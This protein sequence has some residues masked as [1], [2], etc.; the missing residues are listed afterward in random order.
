MAKHTFQDGIN[1]VF[2]DELLPNTFVRYLYNG[3]ILSQGE[4]NVGIIT[5][6]KG[7]TQIPFNLPTG[8]NKCIGTAVDEENGKLYWFNYNNTNQHGIYQF[9]RLNKVITPVLLSLEDTGGVDILRFN[10]DY[11]ILHAEVIKG[12]LYWVDGLN[13]ARNFS[14][15]KMLDQG[16]N[17]YGLILEQYINAYKQTSPFPPVAIYASDPS[18]KF[19]KL[20]GSLRKFSIRYVYDGGE[21]SNWSDFSNVPLPSYESFTGVNQIP[22]DNNLINV[23][24]ATGDRTVDKI[25]VAVLTTNYETVGADLPWAIVANIDKDKLVVSDNSQYTFKYYND[26]APITTDN[27]KIIRPYSFMPKRPLCMAFLKNA[28]SYANGYMGFESIDIDVDASV[29]YSDLFIEDGQENEF[30]KPVFLHSLPANGADYV[31]DHERLWDYNNVEGFLLARDAPGRFNIHQITVGNDVKAGNKFRLQLTNGSDNFVIEVTAIN[32]DTSGTIINKIRQQL[33]A[34]P[35]RIFRRTE[36]L[37]DTNIFDQIDDGSGNI[38]IKFII[39]ASKN[40]PYLQGSASVQP[41]QFNTLK[42]TGQSVRNIKMGSQTKYGLMYEDFDGRKSLVYTDNN[43]IV[44]IQTFNEAGEIK[45]ST[46]T[47]NINHLPP[48]WARYYQVVRSSDLV[49][50]DY[51]QMMIQKVSPFN[52]D[53]DA[54]DYL[55]LAVGSLYTF[56][57]LHPNA[58]LRYEFKKGDRLRLLKKMDTDGVYDFFETEIISYNVNTTERKESNLKTNGTT[59]VTVASASTSDI[60]KFIS[61]EDGTTREI[62]DV[63]NGTTYTLNNVVGTTEEKTYLYYDLTDNRGSI[64]IRKPSDVTIVNNSLVEIFTPATIGFDE[65]IQ[66][67]EFQKKFEILG[68][69]TENAYHAGSTQNQTASQPAI[70]KIS[71]GTAYVRNRELPLNNSVPGTQIVV[72]VVEDQSYSD[73][74]SSLMNDNGRLNIEDNGDGEV[75]FGSRVWYS[76]NFIEDTR[77][78]GLNDFDNTNREDYNDQYGDIKLTKFDTNRIY[79][80]KELKTAYIPV[81]SRITQDNAGLA[82]NVTSNKLLNPIQYFAWEGGIGNHPSSYAY[83]GTQRYIVSVNSGVII[84]IGGNGEEPISKTYLFDNEIKRLLTEADKNNAKIIGGFDR[85]NGVYIVTIEGYQKYIYFDG[86]NTWILEDA[87]LAED[88]IFE[89]VTPPTNGDA[90][91]VDNTIVYTPDTS[92]IGNDTFS[93]RVQIGGVWQVAKNVCIE[94]IDV[95]SEVSWRP[96]DA[97]CVVDQ[98]GLRTGYQGFNNL[99]EYTVFDNAPTGNTIPNVQSDPRYVAP[100]YNPDDCIPQEPD[101]N[102]DPFT[103]TPVT[104]ANTSMIYVS[105]TQTLTGF[106]IPAT[107]SV[108]GGEYRVNG[109]A[110]TSANGTVNVN[111]V[112]Q[113]RQTSSASDE[114]LT[115]TTLT[116]GSQSADYNVTT[117]SSAIPCGAGTSYSGGESFPTEQLVTLGTGTGLVTLT[118]NAYSAPDKFRV[119]YPSGSG[120]YVIDTGYR[121]DSSQQSALDA[122]LAARSLPPEPIVGVGAGTA[123]FTKSGTEATAKV[124]VFAPLSGTAWDFNLGCPE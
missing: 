54:Q 11:P 101:P 106:N 72:G 115:T 45:A 48:K 17:G 58:T 94:V 50:G 7:N 110:W 43:L 76:N 104:D 24:F 21:Y 122:A 2:A 28:L 67:F 33:I 55:D 70:V 88:V 112:V 91:I 86:F 69:G 53:D 124:Q 31:S 46:I 6:T 73:F 103:F 93:Y 82:L 47:L 52:D 37:P 57:R 95:P 84:R 105:N 121:G 42:D 14:I 12:R 66:F 62:M 20:Y 65:N 117:G 9:D 114:T 36:E 1:T 3:N 80:F 109:G 23:T 113:V 123:S 60:G 22:T 81:D 34:L 5:N 75:H 111:D 29:A 97:Y 39:R 78:N 77:I 87:N 19:N 51:I 8:Q 16:T 4:G 30:N 102:P 18:K 49:Y 68:A 38:T 118:F 96:I 100:V 107:I 119:E 64:R 44:P 56:Q 26:V 89:V 63:P 83:N 116:V 79:T 99:Q 90:T 15:A 71:E 13:P 59:N 74:Y 85:F 40:K 92:Y 108:V 120:I 41:V 27:A 32:T 98:Y 35:W 10:P 61:L 25:Q